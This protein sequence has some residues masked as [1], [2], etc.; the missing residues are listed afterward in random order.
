MLQASDQRSYDDDRSRA[1]SNCDLFFLPGDHL[2]TE[3][4]RFFSCPLPGGAILIGIGVGT[5]LSVAEAVTATS[6]TS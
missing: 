6:T 1:P 4:K 2:C 5:A 3:R